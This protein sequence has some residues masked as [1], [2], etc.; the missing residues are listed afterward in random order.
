MTHGAA[1]AGGSA[2]AADYSF[3]FHRLFGDA[4]GNRSVSTLDFNAFRK[5]LG[6]TVGQPGYQAAFD[7]DGNGSVNTLDFN[8][9]KARLGTSLP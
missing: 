9:F 1:G 4:D 3:S 8:R 5:A 7:Y 6:S 2:M